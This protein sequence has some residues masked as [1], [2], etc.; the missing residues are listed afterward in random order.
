MSTQQLLNHSPAQL[1]N[2]LNQVFAEQH[3]TL[4]QW[5]KQQ[6]LDREIVLQHLESSGF[7]Y[8]PERNRIE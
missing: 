1:A 2:L 6:A 3:C 8:L 4:E 5:V 7:F